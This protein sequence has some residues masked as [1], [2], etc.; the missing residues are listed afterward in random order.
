MCAYMT[1]YMYNHYLFPFGFSYRN[2]RP[3]IS[4]LYSNVVSHICQLHAKHRIYFAVILDI[5][6]EY[7]VICN[8]TQSVNIFNTS[9]MYSM[10]SKAI[11]EH[12]LAA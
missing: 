9:E 2:H 12:Y 7:S 6:A 1:F 11:E 8:K 5:V 10:A 4:Y 3:C